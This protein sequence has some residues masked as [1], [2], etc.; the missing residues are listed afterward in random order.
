MKK[1]DKE[2]Q[3]EI[4]LLREKSVETQIAYLMGM[5]RIREAREIFMTR[6]NKSADLYGEKLKRFNMDAAWQMLKIK[7]EYKEAVNEFLKTDID[8]RELILLFK[9][10]YDTSNNLKKMVVGV[11]T[12]FLRNYLQNFYLN[13]TS[14]PEIEKKHKEAK[15]A[16]RGLLEKLN[17]KYVSELRKDPNKEAEFMVSTFSDISAKIR[18]D[19]YKL[20]DILSL[21]QMAIIKMYIEADKD[22]DME[23]KVLDFFNEMGSTSGQAPT[24]HSTAISSLIENR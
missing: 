3:S 1:S 13:N 22:G 12:T 19:R 7:L 18:G 20:K 14:T 11:P 6:G 23:P 24:A 4:Y 21:V 2:T 16:I 8:P 15:D 9:D 5:C 10:L 17:A